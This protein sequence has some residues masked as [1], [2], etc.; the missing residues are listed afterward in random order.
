MLKDFTFLRKNCF[1]VPKSKRKPQ[2]PHGHAGCHHTYAEQSSSISYGCLQ[3]PAQGHTALQGSD[4][5]Q[6]H[7]GLGQMSPPASGVIAS[8]TTAVEAF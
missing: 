7:P 2:S 5:T 4:K 8:R 6:M 3:L 1:H